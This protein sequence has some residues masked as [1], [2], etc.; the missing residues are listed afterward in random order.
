MPDSRGG[1]FSV[2]PALWRQSLGEGVTWGR[3]LNF[4][5]F[6]EVKEL[7]CLPYN[8]ETLLNMWPFN[9]IGGRWI[10]GDRYVMLAK[11]C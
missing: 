8:I 9:Y 4:S 7:K 2:K 11:E 10:D 5:E 3:I 1:C 6:P